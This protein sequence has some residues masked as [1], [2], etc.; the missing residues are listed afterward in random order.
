M[1]PT[2]RASKADGTQF[3]LALV[4]APRLNTFMSKGSSFP[5]ALASNS[6]FSRPVAWSN[7]SFITVNK[8]QIIEIIQFKCA[9]ADEKSI[10]SRR[11]VKII[12]NQVKSLW[13]GV[14]IYEL[15]RLAPDIH[16][17]GFHI[18]RYHDLMHQI[19][20]I[21]LCNESTQKF[22]LIH[23]LLGRSIFVLSGYSL[24]QK[25]TGV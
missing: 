10:R 2:R 15:F 7:G 23:G 19:D 17:A 8:R 6:R 5:A 12:E 9:L 18:T 20:Q 21:V 3:G 1:H 4:P 13:E 24:L 14:K 11:K 25:R 16:I 22:S